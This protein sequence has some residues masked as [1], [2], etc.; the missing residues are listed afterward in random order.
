M[1]SSAFGKLQVV[2]IVR[3]VIIVVSFFYICDSKQRITGM[4]KIL[5]VMAFLSFSVALKAQDITGHWGGKLNIQGIQLRV[6]FHIARSGDA[7]VTTMDSPDQGAKGIPTGKTEYSNSVL[8]IVAPGMG[9]T[10]T[11]TWQGNDTIKGTFMQSG[12]T[13]PLEL[14]R[15]E[16][17]SLRPQEPK[18]PYPYHTEEVTVENVKAGVKLAGTLTLPEREGDYPVVILI[19]GS[20]PQNR[21]EE[22]EGHKPFLVIADYLT[23]QGIG[24]LR[25]DD[26]GV[27]LSTGDFGKATTMDFAD[28]IEAA[29]I[30][31]KNRKVRQVGLIGH[32]EGGMIAPLVATRTN[33]VDFIILLAGPGLRG[34]QILLG[35]Q[36][37]ISRA[38]GMADSVLNYSKM[39]NKKC[40]DMVVQSGSEDKAEGALKNYMDSLNRMGRLPAN[41][42][43]EQGAEL[44]RR[45]VLSPWMYF[46][47]TYDPVPTLERVKCPVLALNGSNDLQVLPEN[48]EIIKKALEAGGNRQVTVKELPGLNHLFQTCKSG[49]PTLYGTITETFSPVALK[50]IGEWIGKL[51]VK[52]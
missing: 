11:G 34:D 2:L 38:L 44:W 18:P 37:A 21:D 27:G 39:V 23:R 17:N 29:V 40:L 43:N 4:N 42:K 26:R 52:N 6:I 20:G 41:M 25:L 28:D 50:E 15:T 14:I 45:Q 19:T 51:K 30:F 36:E 47:V 46:F 49:S 16:E 24:V 5:I 3:F 8:T 9:M 48:L 32:S 1:D 35:Q 13:L 31:L 33:D 12:M 22:I 10:Y 7:Y